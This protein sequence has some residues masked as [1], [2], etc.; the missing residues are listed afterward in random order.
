MKIYL[1]TDM[2]Q[3]GMTWEFRTTRK[4]AEAYVADRLA[5]HEPFGDRGSSALPEISTWDVRPTRD[6]ITTALNDFVSLICL[7]EF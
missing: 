5:E 4:L 3:R 6:G 2:L 7:N 1:I